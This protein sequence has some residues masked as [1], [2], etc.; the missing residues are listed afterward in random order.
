MQVYCCQF[1]LPQCNK[2]MAVQIGQ[3]CLAVGHQRSHLATILTGNFCYVES[4]D[5]LH[6]CV[7]R[8]RLLLKVS[9]V[10]VLS[11]TSSGGGMWVCTKAGNL[12]YLYGLGSDYPLANTYEE[13]NDIHSPMCL[14]CTLHYFCRYGS[15]NFPPCPE[16]TILQINILTLSCKPQRQ[17]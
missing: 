7:S 6:V 16:E 2:N 13:V 4:T 12:S 5:S 17:I 1:T 3:F 14:L 11:L 15:C 10:F 9:C 8:S